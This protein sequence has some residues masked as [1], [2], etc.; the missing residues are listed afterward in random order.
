[1][2]PLNAE[3][4]LRRLMETRLPAVN[5][6]GCHFSPVQGLTGESWRIDGS[7]VTL[8]ARQHSAEK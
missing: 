2:A 5:T 6:A 3:A 1:M 4:A 8:L 7:G